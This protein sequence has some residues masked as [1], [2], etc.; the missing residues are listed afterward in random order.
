VLVLVLAADGAVAAAGS[1]A[2]SCS[3]T[4]ERDI[5]YASI[6]GVEPSLLSLDVAPTPG[7]CAAPVALWV[8]GG[9]WRVG[10]KT[11]DAEARAAFYNEQGW[12][13]VSVNYRLAVQGLEPPVAYPDFNQDVAAALNW[14]HDEIA[15]R[16]GDP[17][18][19]LLVGHSAG[20]GIA[21]AVIADPR[22]LEPHG[23]TPDWI[24][25]AVL[26]DTEGYDVAA[27]A[28]RGGE[29]GAIY[30]NAF[31]DDPLVWADA[32]PSTHVGE[33]VLPAHV[34]VVTRGTP[35]RTS[36]A[37]A[38][39]HQLRLDGSDVTVFDANPLSHADVNRLIG[40][41]DP[42]MTPLMTSTLERCS[43]TT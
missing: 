22:Y 31:G 36:A 1:P 4:A 7:E 35:R 15:D 16:G 37:D 5:V 28:G 19:V 33:G 42:T 29:L 30:Q 21:A 43:E 40:S 20:A 13:L 3:A 17:D 10:D 2:T 34:L 27:M 38:F 14:V 8:H 11:N 12:T 23:L 18:R 32:S 6:D 39:G 25:C 24:D 41:G 9:G 26:L